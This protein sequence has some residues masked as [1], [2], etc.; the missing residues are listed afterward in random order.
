MVTIVPS[1]VFSGCSVVT[2]EVSEGEKADWTTAERSESE[3]WFRCG[4]Y[5][6]AEI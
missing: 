1:D 2:L 4:S 5:L 6:K 3:V